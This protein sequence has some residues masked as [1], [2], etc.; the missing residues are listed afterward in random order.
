MVV[1]GTHDWESV[2]RMIEEEILSTNYNVFFRP[3]VR[4]ES[5]FKLT[6]PS[7]G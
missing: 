2:W 1:G 3:K 4:N 6:K 7:T 5:G